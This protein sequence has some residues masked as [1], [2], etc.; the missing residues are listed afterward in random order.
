MGQGAPWAAAAATALLLGGCSG[1][2]FGEQLSRSF[3]APAPG[4]STTAT[5]AKPATTTSAT[6]DKP[7]AAPPA[8]ALPEPQPAKPVQAM[9]P[10]PYRITIQLPAADPSAPAEVVTEALRKAG[11]PFEV[12]MIERVSSSGT[13]TTQAPAPVQAPQPRPTTPTRRR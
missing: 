9:P 5:P 12:E 8:A 11:V 10:A 2:P 3:S 13:T 4:S 7:V 6:A 1:T